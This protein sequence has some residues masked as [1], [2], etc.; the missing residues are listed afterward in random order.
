MYPF[1][2]QVCFYKP[3]NVGYRY[4]YAEATADLT[5][6]PQYHWEL[7]EWSDC[8]VK[9]GGGT[10]SAKYECVEE[11]AGRVSSSFC[12]GEDK[13]ESDTKKCNER[14]CKRK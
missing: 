9:C 14:P 8:T 11:K 10:Q 7:L 13:P 1:L 4:K 12:V 5:Y 3:E 6:S 2:F